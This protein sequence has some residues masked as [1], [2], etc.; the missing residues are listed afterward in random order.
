MRRI[1]QDG[2]SQKEAPDNIVGMVLNDFRK[3][4]IIAMFADDFLF[5]KLVLK[6]G[7]AISLVY[8]YGNRGSLDVD[9]SM[10]D[11]FPDH[12]AAG[13]RIF[14]ALQ[15]RFDAAG[16]VVFDY[17]FGPKPTERKADWP[18]SWGGYRAEFKIIEQT[19]HDSLGGDIESIRRNASVLGPRQLRTFVID[20]S[21]FEYCQPKSEKELERYTIFA[22][23]PAMLAIEKVRAICQQM[24]QYDLKSTKTPSARDFYD[25][26]LLITSGQVDFQTDESA[27]LARKIFDA[28]QV[29]LSLME[30]IE[31][32]REFHR[33]DWPAVVDSVS[34]ALENYD[35]YFDFVVNEC[36]KLKTGRDE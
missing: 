26:W 5:E 9:F 2:G 29:P 21:K 31:E 14:R 34:G 33:P 4:V 19:K 1:L 8:G 22:Y 11:E 18:A 27:D 13:E 32:F 3:L 16:Y 36:R 30:K 35:N 28:K 17:R 12:A 25:I 24:P 6:G 15:D 7:N 20:I 10:E 23:T